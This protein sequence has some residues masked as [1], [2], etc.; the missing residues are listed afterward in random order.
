MSKLKRTI[1]IIFI[2]LLGIGLEVLNFYVFALNDKLYKV[3]FAMA[4][5][6]IIFV[7]IFGNIM[8]YYYLENKKGIE[9]ECINVFN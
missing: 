6:Y 4:G 1:L 2:A 5:M 9:N 8:F 3:G 7:S